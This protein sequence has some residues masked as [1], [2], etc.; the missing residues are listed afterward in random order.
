[1]F[2][3]TLCAHGSSEIRQ[4]EPIKAI[5]FPTP[6]VPSG[7]LPG[8]WVKISPPLNGR[9]FGFNNREVDTVLLVSNKKPEDFYTLKIS[10]FVVNLY[11]PNDIDNPLKEIQLGHEMS[12]YNEAEIHPTREA[13]ESR[14]R[15]YQIGYK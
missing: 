6:H 15:E 11:V 2:S 14:L 10:P 12:G 7:F 9:S 3:L 4:C 8:L 1:M 5:D 13:A